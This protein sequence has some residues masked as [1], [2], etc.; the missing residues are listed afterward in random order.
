MGG[1]EDGFVGGGLRRTVISL[2]I[3]PWVKFTDCVV[4]L[5]CAITVRS[6]FS[7]RYI[8]THAENVIKILW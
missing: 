4:G 8:M 2:S 1:R 7:L 3:Y 5:Q 6:A